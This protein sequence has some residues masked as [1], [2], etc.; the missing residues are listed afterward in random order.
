MNIQ[1]FDV[2]A[3]YKITRVNWKTPF[4][5]VITGRESIN[6]ILEPTDEFN[7]TLDGEKPP[8]MA[9]SDWQNVLRVKCLDSG[10]VHLLDPLIVSHAVKLD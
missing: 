9:I 10:K 6:L 7:T 2:G 1:D 5:E 8:K 3:T 4:G